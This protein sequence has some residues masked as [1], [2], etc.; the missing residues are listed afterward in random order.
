MY[1]GNPLSADT[2]ATQNPNLLEDH[3]PTVSSIRSSHTP[4]PSRP[5][6]A[7]QYSPFLMSGSEMRMLV[8]KIV[9]HYIYARHVKNYDSNVK[10]I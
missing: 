5:V 1:W 10:R 3:D 9:I 8:R 4:V 2:L 7:I 6:H